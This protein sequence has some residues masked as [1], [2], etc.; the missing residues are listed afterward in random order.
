MVEVD[1]RE[2][3]KTRKGYLGR[4]MKKKGEWRRVKEGFN[5][6]YK[7][8]IFLSITLIMLLILIFLNLIV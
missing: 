2:G 3:Q 7:N 8:N 6:C 4:E 5:K 1:W